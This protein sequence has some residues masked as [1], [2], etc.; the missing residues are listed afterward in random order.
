[1]EIEP[2]VDHDNRAAHRRTLLA[3]ASWRARRAAVALEALGE[4]V[5][6]LPRGSRVIVASPVV[7]RTVCGCDDW[8]YGDPERVAQAS[9]PTM[10]RMRIDYAA[11]EPR[12]ADV[13][14][15]LLTAGPG[16]EAY[17]TPRGGYPC[18]F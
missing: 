6:A 9:L 12:M 2:R 15:W 7:A 5:M 11:I 16:T 1:M 4:Y 18:P 8:P 14:G 17:A 3:P 10:T 13:S